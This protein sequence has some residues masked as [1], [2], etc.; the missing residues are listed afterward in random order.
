MDIDKEIHEQNISNLIMEFC[1]PEEKIREAYSKAMSEVDINTSEFY[2]F[3]VYR[4]AR[5]ELKK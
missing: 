1:M 4:C 5:N 3:A 2:P